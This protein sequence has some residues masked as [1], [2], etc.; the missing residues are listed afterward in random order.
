MPLDIAISVAAIEPMIKVQW[1]IKTITAATSNW[2]RLKRKKKL[3]LLSSI[4][5]QRTHRLEQLE[6]LEYFTTD[7]MGNPTPAF[8]NE[9]N[10]RI[11]INE[12]SIVVNAQ[13]ISG[14][15]IL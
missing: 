5:A 12:Q 13:H 9:N 15:K 6:R 8:V 7:S 4:Q 10:P 11:D 2:S 14:K 1:F 3:L